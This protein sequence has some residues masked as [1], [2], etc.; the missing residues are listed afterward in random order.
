LLWTPSSWRGSPLAHTISR[1]TDDQLFDPR[2][3]AEAATHLCEISLYD[4]VK[5]TWPHIESAASV[6]NWYIGANREH[7]DCAPGQAKR[8]T[9]VTDSKTSARQDSMPPIK[10]LVQAPVSV[11]DEGSRPTPGSQLRLL[12]THHLE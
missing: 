5:E 3:L 8:G 9:L 10:G 6:H 2:L 12:E 7:V 1:M 4:N 11:S